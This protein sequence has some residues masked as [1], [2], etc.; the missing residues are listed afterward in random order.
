MAIKHTV[1]VNNENINY[2]LRK[3]HLTAVILIIIINNIVLITNFI[4]LNAIMW[5]MALKYFLK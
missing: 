2:K 3:Q 4:Y 1:L 5:S